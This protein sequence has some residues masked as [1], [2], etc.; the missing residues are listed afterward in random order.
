MKAAT[1]IAHPPKP[2]TVAELKQQLDAIGGLAKRRAGGQAKR[3]RGT[4]TV[5]VRPAG[6]RLPA[7]TVKNGRDAIVCL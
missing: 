7:C 5:V 6:K 4:G 3:R 1:T 2:M